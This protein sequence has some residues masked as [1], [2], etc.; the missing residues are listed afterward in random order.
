MHPERNKQHK[1]AKPWVYYREF[2]P[3]RDKI[4]LVCTMFQRESLLEIQSFIVSCLSP[5]IRDSLS[6]QSMCVLQNIIPF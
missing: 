6:S 3:R 4:K 2:Q 1:K 5:P